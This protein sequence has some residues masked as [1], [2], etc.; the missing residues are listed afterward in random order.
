MNQI[1]IGLMII[2]SF[3]IMAEGLVFK[4]AWV[5][6]VPRVSQVS[7]GFGIL[8]N[9]TNRDRKLVK[10]ESTISKIVEIHT[11]T[12]KN[13]VMRMR[14]IDFINIR[15][16]SEVALKPMSYHIMFIDLVAPLK[17]GDT[18]PVTLIFDNGERIE[19]QIKIVK[20]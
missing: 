10:V 7:A 2:F 4:K 20:I 3:Q 9:E 8:V 17:A 12:R 16:M 13:G 11:H 14:K 18:A 1:L 15:K 6:A 19:N 5:R